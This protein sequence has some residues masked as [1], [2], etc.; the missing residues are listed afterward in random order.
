MSESIQEI[1]KGY[2]HA[3]LS[4]VKVLLIFN[5]ST[6]FLLFWL[7][8]SILGCGD[9]WLVDTMQI[10]HTVL[11][12]IIIF[13]YKILKFKTHKE[14]LKNIDE[15]LVYLQE[16]GAN[17]YLER[18]FQEIE[19]IIEDKAHMEVKE[20]IRAHTLYLLR[21]RYIIDHL[22]IKNFDKYYRLIGKSLDKVDKSVY[23]AY[24]YSYYRTQSRFD[25]QYA[26][27]MTDFDLMDNSSFG[28]DML[29]LYFIEKIHTLSDEKKRLFKE[30]EAMLKDLDDPNYAKNLIHDCYE[31]HAK[32]GTVATLAA[33]M[34]ANKERTEKLRS[35]LDRIE[36]IQ[37]M[38]CSD[39][40][41]PVYKEEE[42]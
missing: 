5:I 36:E 23:K 15:I 16:N 37:Y 9:F 4:R 41:Y 31:K 12:L 34:E 21:T 28:L 24:V 39:I 19:D 7:L 40:T 26:I 1:V 32:D 17:A 30:N 8:M 35:N 11:N 13:K 42:S 3:P 6:A 2:T 33:I 10:F 14:D 27:D 38:L 18:V 22:P 25:P 20:F 29:T